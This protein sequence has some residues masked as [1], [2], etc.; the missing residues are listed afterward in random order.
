MN[1]F[2][3][4]H[5]VNLFHLLTSTFPNRICSDYRIIK[6]LMIMF[7]HS[8]PLVRFRERLQF[9]LNIEKVYN[10]LKH[11]SLMFRLQTLVST[12]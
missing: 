5:T 3:N 10:D 4:L 7:R 1:V 12:L 2:K 8:K 9:C 6:V 11:Q